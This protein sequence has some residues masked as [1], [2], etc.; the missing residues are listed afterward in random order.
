MTHNLKSGLS[1]GRIICSALTLAFA[2]SFF[3][4]NAAIT[5]LGRCDFDNAT[6]N[7]VPSSME[8]FQ[9][10]TP[11]VLAAPI[12]LMNGLVY[13]APQPSIGITSLGNQILRDNMS[14]SAPRTF[15]V[16]EPGINFFASNP[17]LGESDEYNVSIRTVGGDILTISGRRGKK[18]DG[19]FGVEITDDTL[20]SVTFIVTFDS[21]SGGKDGGGVGNYAID[22]VAVGTAANPINIDC[23]DGDG[24]GGRG[25]GGRDEE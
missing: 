20:L 12:T 18:F 13:S 7:G 25:R 3:S 9:S 16:V 15:M 8:D 23:R 19:F 14:A 21:N 24:G 1:T 10:W 11:G 17:L 4:V 2:S 22:N 5:E 6:S